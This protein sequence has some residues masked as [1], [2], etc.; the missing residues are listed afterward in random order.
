M[1]WPDGPAAGS[2]GV[3]SNATKLA[4]RDDKDEYLPWGSYSRY[5]GSMAAFTLGKDC[6]HWSA[7][8]P[9]GHCGPS[10]TARSIYRYIY[11]CSTIL[12]N[13]TFA[14]TDHPLQAA[15]NISTD[16]M[17]IQIPKSMKAL[18]QQ[19]VSI[20]RGSHT[21]SPV[22]ADCEPRCLQGKKVAVVDHPTPQLEENDVLVK[23]EYVGLNPTG[24]SSSSLS[25]R[26]RQLSD[27][28]FPHR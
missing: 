25:T 10:I 17:S 23:V 15:A 1:Y 8:P 20:S 6:D 9:I 3:A 22:Q 16:P 4:F 26:G 13:P 21:L 11:G 12:H 24:T 28:G 19:E 18:I 7:T 27:P 14:L 5:E 2:K